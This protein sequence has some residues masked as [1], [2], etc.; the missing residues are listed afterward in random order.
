[1]PEVKVAFE[2]AVSNRFSTFNPEV[3]DLEDDISRN[4]PK[5]NQSI[6]DYM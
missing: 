1:V 2:G 4:Q 5:C 3:S 6:Y